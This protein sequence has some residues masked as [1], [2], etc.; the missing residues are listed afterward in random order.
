MTVANVDPDSP[1]AGSAPSGA[2][3]GATPTA[4]STAH[5]PAIGDLAFLSDG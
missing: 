3:E 1:A 5:F 2:P 4:H